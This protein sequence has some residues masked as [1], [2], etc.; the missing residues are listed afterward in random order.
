MFGKLISVKTLLINLCNPRQGK[1]RIY[2]QEMFF[3]RQK[4]QETFSVSVHK[5]TNLVQMFS[6]N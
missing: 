2:S 6:N 3:L 5:Y 4:Q 1:M